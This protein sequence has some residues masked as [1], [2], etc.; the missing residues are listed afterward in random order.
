MSG[1]CSGR[2]AGWGLCVCILAM[3]SA[4]AVEWVRLRLFHEG[5]VLPETFSHD[6]RPASR[7]VRLSVFCQIPQYLLVGLSEVP[8]A[9][10]QPVRPPHPSPSSKQGAPRSEK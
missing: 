10:L 9:P 4:A 7:V 1:L 5:D 6:G 2:L 8:P 3:L